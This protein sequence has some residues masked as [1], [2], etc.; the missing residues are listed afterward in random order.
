MDWK[1]SSGAYHV[2]Y[3]DDED[4]KEAFLRMAF[5]RRALEVCKAVLFNS[6][7]GESQIDYTYDETPERGGF[8]G[9]VGGARGRERHVKNV[10]IRGD[11]HCQSQ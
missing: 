4:A 11:V 2:E 10:T 9:V 1:I 8:V 5:N 6:Y 3:V 7:L